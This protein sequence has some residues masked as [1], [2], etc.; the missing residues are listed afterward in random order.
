VPSVASA[1]PGS[2]TVFSKANLA[3]R[4]AYA[5]DTATVAAHPEW[6]LK[7][8]FGNRVY[9]GTAVAAD[10][11]NPAYRAWWIAQVAGQRALYV[12][13]VTME[14]RV[15]TNFGV[16]TNP[17]DPRTGARMTEANWQR[18]MA[19]FMVELRTALPTA[20]IVHDVLWAEGDGGAQIARELAAASSVAIEKGFNDPAILNPATWESLAGYVARRQ[21]A[22]HR[23][24][25]DGYAEAPAA[26][27]YGLGVGLLLDAGAIVLGNDAWTAPNRF[28]PGYDVALGAPTTGRYQWSGV[29][30]RDFVNGTV[31]VNQ[32]GNGSRGVSVGSGFADLDGVAQDQLT[33][34]AASAAVLKRVPV[35]TKPVP[36]P[37]PPV[38]TAPIEPAVSTPVATPTPT[39]PRP[40]RP[41]S[42]VTA[43]IAGAAGPRATITTVTVSRLEVSGRVTGAVSGYVRV[44]VQ[45]KRGK[46]WST[47]RRVKPSVSRR[48]TFKAPIARLSR[49][50]YRVVATFEGT[51]TAIPSRSQYKQRAL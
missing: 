12:D 3:R 15:H 30:R 50:S 44:S 35:V 22:G 48:G 13:D 27:L 25:L 39:P 34:A 36:P 14:R 11:G 40:V 17:R 2:V 41:S 8:V 47:V 9:L 26:R 29:W 42:A 19:D 43:H 20:E 6:I 28:W 24:I 33:L 46:G 38:T 4:S 32:P 16:L 37:P 21:A 18:Y 51:G 10:F 23:V 7:D 45:R 1:A 5:L 31:L 49:G